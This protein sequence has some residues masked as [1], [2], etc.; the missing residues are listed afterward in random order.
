MLAL[1]AQDLAGAALLVTDVIM[2]EMSGLALAAELTARFPRLRVLYISGYAPEVIG[3]GLAP[4]GARH[5][6]KPFTPDALVR[7][8]REVLDART[9]A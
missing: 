2:P 8:V 5:L 6:S 1:D 9:P 7:E 4:A 3:R